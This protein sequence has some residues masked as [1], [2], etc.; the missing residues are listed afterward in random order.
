MVNQTLITKQQIQNSYIVE[1]RAREYEKQRFLHPFWRM[2]HEKEVEIINNFFK[3]IKPKRILE[4]AVGTGRV[5]RNLKYF[6]EG[7]GVDNSEAM[8]KVAESVIATRPAPFPKEAGRR[9][10]PVV[11]GT[12]KGLR[13]FK[14]NDFRG[15]SKSSPARLLRSVRQ[16]SDLPRNDSESVASRK[17]TL[18]KGDAFD[19]PFEKN[20]FDAVLSF[21]FIRHFSKQDREKILK[22]ALRVLKPGGYLIFEALNKNMGNYAKKITSI[23]KKNLFDKPIY[24]ELWTKEELEQELES[25]G[26]SEIQFFPYLKILNKLWGIYQIAA[27]ARLLGFGFVFKWLFRWLD[28]FWKGEPFQ[29]EIICRK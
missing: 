26:F 29:W 11:N 27:A 25:I 21:R 5:A 23:N 28:G 17:W 14:N 18:L 9:G 6:E 20:T 2:A 8:L 16:E 19:L 15:S 22:Q 24:D 10:N 1:K 7:V 4:V 13:P 12:R 3:K